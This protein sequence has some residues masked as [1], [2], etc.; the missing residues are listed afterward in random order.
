MRTVADNTLLFSGPVSDCETSDIEAF[1]QESI[2]AQIDLD[3][4]G[5]LPL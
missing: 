5:F 4:I 3:F 2:L 1:R